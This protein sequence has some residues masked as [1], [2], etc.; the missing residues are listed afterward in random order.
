MGNFHGFRKK[1]ISFGASPDEISEFLS[2]VEPLD[3]IVFRGCDVISNAIVNIENYKTKCDK[4]SH[5]EIAITREWC[6]KIKPIKSKTNVKDNKNTLFSWGS[7]MSGKNNDGVYNAETGK[8]YFGVQ[9]RVLEDLVRG[10]L[11][12]PGANVGVCK[13]L[14]NPTRIKID[15]P[16][17]HF[18][19]RSQL[20]KAKIRAA[21]DMYNGRKYNANLLTLLG[22][23]FPKLRKLRSFSNKIVNSINKDLQKMLFCSEWVAIFYEMVGV[24]TDETDGVIDGKMPLPEN[25]I[26]VDFLGADEDLDGI[27]EPICQSIPVWI[28]F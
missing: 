24:I 5:V 22:A 13:L 25:I 28:K 2:I 17:D 15:E 3:L 16:I 23:I 4:I 10:Y 27:V 9:I 8:S 6:E 21:Y 12:T 19:I 1:N 11:A 7:T 20:L 26:P 18:T 14:N